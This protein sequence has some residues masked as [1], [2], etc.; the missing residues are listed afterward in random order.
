MPETNILR[1][2]KTMYPHLSDFERAAIIEADCEAATKRRHNRILWQGISD[3]AGS[4]RPLLLMM[5]PV[6]KEA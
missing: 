1:R 6:K 2:F 3:L 5:R 4:L